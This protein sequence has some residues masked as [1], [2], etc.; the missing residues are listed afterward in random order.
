MSRETYLCKGIPIPKTTENKV[1]YRHF[2]YL[3]LLVIKRTTILLLNKSK[4]DFSGVRMQTSK[5]CEVW[6]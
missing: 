4:H 2:G 1:Q 3:N 5:G 6:P